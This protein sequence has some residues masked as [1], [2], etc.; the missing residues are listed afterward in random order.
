M[1]ANDAEKVMSRV[2]NKIIGE[3]RRM[4]EDRYTLE[5]IGLTLGVSKPTVQRWLEGE[6]GGEKTAFIDII[7]YT[8][9][10][11]LNLGSIID[12]ASPPLPK[13]SKNGEDA[14]RAENTKLSAELLD[15]QR[16]LLQ[17]KSKL[18]E[19]QDKLL[20]SEKEKVELSANARRVGAVSFPDLPPIHLH[21]R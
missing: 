13:N 5:R 19:A 1:A 17:A 3:V 11:K 7:R 12:D 18:I 21:R 16:E 20:Q 15:I 9:A 6:A 2:W 8:N 10:L 14:L 4:R